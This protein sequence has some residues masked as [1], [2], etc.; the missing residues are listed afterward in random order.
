MPR[1]IN[2]VPRGERA[3][4]TTNVGMLAVVVSAIVVL[5]ALALGYYMFSN[6]LSD[7][8][9][10][11]ENLQQERAALEAQVSA[12]QAYERL[13]SQR[14]GTETVVQGI[15]ASRTLVAPILGDISLVIPE[16]VWFVSMSLSAADPLAP[17]PLAAGAATGAETA[18]NGTLTLE[19]DTYSFE[20]VAQFL[21]RMQLIQ[22]LSGIDLL[23][24][25]EPIGNVDQTKDVK[26]F[27]IAAF[28]NNTQ[29]EEAVL[30]LS[31]VEVEGL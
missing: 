11:L 16:N 30:P 26:G 18:S 13:A 24:A 28:V 31:Q 12:L 27:S 15:Y 21:V 4:T 3:R 9:S 22:G 23:S 10:A 14:K 1:R 17:D 7:R 2:L 20:D 6:S 5:F 19:G 29:D 25:G 8:K